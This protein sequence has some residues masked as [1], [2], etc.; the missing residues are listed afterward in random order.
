MYMEIY[1]TE[2]KK[3]LFTLSFMNGGVAGSLKQ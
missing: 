1:N 2:E 3:V